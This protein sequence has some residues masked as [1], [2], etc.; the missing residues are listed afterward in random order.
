MVSSS[1]EDDDD[2]EEKK[3]EEKAT[4]SSMVLLKKGAIAWVP[5]HSKNWSHGHFIML[6]MES[7]KIVE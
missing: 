3:E 6:Q 7:Q 5:K 1:L 4:K 2:E